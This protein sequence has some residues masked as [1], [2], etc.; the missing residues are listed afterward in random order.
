M[1]LQITFSS[2]LVAALAAGSSQLADLEPRDNSAQCDCYVVSGKEP[3]YFQYHRFLDF[4][5]IT[6]SDADNFNTPPPLITAAENQ[7]GQN[8]T[9]TYFNTTAF[10][11][12]WFIT[13]KVER[14]NVPVSLVNSVQNVFISSGLDGS[15]STYLAL[16]VSR[17]DQFASGSEIDSYQQ[18][19]LHGSFRARMR[20]IPNFDNASSPFVDNGVSTANIPG[21]NASHPVAPGGCLGFFTYHS[22][23]EESDIEILTLDPLTDI[24]YSNQPD[25]DAQTGN[26]IPGASTD[27]VMPNNIIWTDW[28]DHRVDWFD[29]MSRWYVD[30]QLVLEKTFHVP[31][32]PSSVVLNL[33]SDG[34]NWSGNMTVGSQIVA[35]VQ[36]I[37]MA[38]NTSGKNPMKRDS[39]SCNIGCTIDNVTTTGSPEVAFN[40]TISARNAAT[41]LNVRGDMTL[42]L[43][44]TFWAILTYGWLMIV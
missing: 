10:S 23:T 5:S 25:Y 7:G 31:T 6:A 3:G 43:A 2:L 20:V 44:L 29:G 39:G 12:D 11:A 42:L 27:A 9:S 35:G 33:W 18:N 19:I 38:F 13:N 16:R 36:W 40:A 15:N 14:T 37:E 4:R 32:K 8:L 24:R 1:L 17:L 28:H 21:I 34:G 41:T 22:D 30:D 26:T